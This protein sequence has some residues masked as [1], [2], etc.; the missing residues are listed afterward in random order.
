MRKDL[1]VF[2]RGTFYR[3]TQ[4]WRSAESD[5]RRA[6]TVLA[7]A[8][9][10]IDSFGTWR[11]IEGR[12]IWGIDDF[13][14]A[15]PL[16]YTNDL[17]RLAT[18][19]AVARH[20]GL[21]TL[22]LKDACR[23]VLDGYTHGL[24]ANGAPIVL[25]ERQDHLDKLGIDE[26]KPPRHFWHNLDAL[27]TARGSVPAGAVR[28]LRATL[29]DRRLAYR[30]VRREAGTGSLGQARYVALA[31]WDGGQIA[32]EAKAL[33]PS[34]C[35]W[36]SGGQRRGQ[37][38]YARSLDG[39]VRAPD[40]FQRVV[41]SWLVRRLSPDSNP[42]LIADLPA[43][44]DEA[45]LLRAMGTET[46]NVHAGTARAIGILRDLRRRRPRWLHHMAHTMAKAVERDWKDYREA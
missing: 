32:R 16:P 10:H 8:D 6:P 38:F 25:A 14:G 20:A 12:L 23:A 2:F 27:P 34:A 43:R 42:I 3:W 17:V 22:G 21:C 11:D 26:L 41:G 33:V 13:D 30:L 31:D 45:L 29:P 28:A 40:P 15:Y 19:I 5:V 37:A 39:A 18:S 4:L 1:F 7:V 9:L 35:V 44:R 36:A 24:R 46:A